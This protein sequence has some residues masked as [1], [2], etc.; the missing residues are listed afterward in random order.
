MAKNNKTLQDY[1]TEELIDEIVERN[2]CDQIGEL[3]NVE[4]CK[5]D[6]DE[7]CNALEKE[8]Y[9]VSEDD[10]FDIE[11]ADDQ[12]L[13]DELESRGYIVDN[14]EDETDIVRRDFERNPT[15]AL[16][17]LQDL[18]GMQHTTTKEQVIEQL[19]NIL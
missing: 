1:T 5:F 3:L 2:E 13:K 14:D 10:I 11:D 17:V 15:A 6:T 4:D 12:D 19:K 18:L 8:G 9:N 7:L 16:N